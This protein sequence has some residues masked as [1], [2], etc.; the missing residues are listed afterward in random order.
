MDSYDDDDN[1]N[2]SH[3]DHHDNPTKEIPEAISRQRSPQLDKKLCRSH[4]RYGYSPGS[5][6]IDQPL[7]TGNV[8]GDEG[9]SSDGEDLIPDS[10]LYMSAMGD[11]TLMDYDNSSDMAMTSS[12]NL[13]NPAGSTT[14]STSMRNRSVTSSAMLGFVGTAFDTTHIPLPNFTTAPMRL[15]HEANFCLNMTMGRTFPYPVD[16]SIRSTSPLGD[17]S[18]PSEQGGD[19][20]LEDHKVEVGKHGLVSI[21]EMYLALARH[22]GC[23]CHGGVLPDEDDYPF[24]VPDLSDMTDFDLW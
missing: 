18:P 9:M 8:S 6:E 23:T 2:Q 15:G 7:S 16:L 24:S 21:R 10:L 14:H 13:T 4:A 3:Y 1:N 20:G 22:R 5:H 17:E 19:E 12:L 11:S